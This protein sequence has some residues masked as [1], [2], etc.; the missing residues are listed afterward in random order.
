VVCNAQKG[1]KKM[2]QKILMILM[3]GILL[4]GAEAAETTNTPL[5]YIIPIKAGIE[6]ALLYVVRRG[7]DEAVRQQAD[8]IIFEM[9]TP[10]GQV[11]AAEGIVNAITRTDIPTYTFVEN[12]GFSAG[13]IIALATKHI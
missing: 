6:P 1:D 12:D 11:N 9:D 4:S 8:A 2:L 3:A 5:V 10:G 13:A 7:I